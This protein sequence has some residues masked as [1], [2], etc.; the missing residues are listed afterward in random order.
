[1]VVSCTCRHEGQDRLYG[2]GKRLANRREPLS[3]A[4]G[5]RF[6]CTA[7]GTTWQFGQVLVVEEFSVSELCDEAQQRLA[8]LFP[9]PR[10]EFVV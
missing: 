1:M 7:C 2:P 9:G 5:P 8:K 3:L 4:S 10:L 6:R